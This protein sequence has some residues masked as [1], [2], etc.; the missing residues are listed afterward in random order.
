MSVLFV[1]GALSASAL[2]IPRI[3]LPYFTLLSQN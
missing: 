1:V 3:S 2:L